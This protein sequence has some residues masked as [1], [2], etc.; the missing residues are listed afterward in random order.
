MGRRVA[1][2]G[3]AQTK[4]EPEKIYPSNQELIWEVVE[5]VQKGTGLSYVDAVADR[6]AI[7]KIVSCSEDFW[8]GRTLSDMQISMQTGGFGLDSTKVP[9]DSTQA[10]YHGVTDIIAGHHDIVLNDKMCIRI[11]QRRSAVVGARE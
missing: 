9:S 3:V 11:I 4:Y 7:D 6:P 5:K 1:I 2:V 8:Q 10:V